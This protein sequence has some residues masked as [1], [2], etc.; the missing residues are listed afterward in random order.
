MP[1]KTNRLI[2]VKI[3]CFVL[4][5]SL[6]LII[7]NDVFMYKSGTDKYKDFYTEKQQ[8]DAL[9]FGSSR[10]LEA[11]QPMELWKEYGIRSYNM[12]QHGEGLGRDYWQLRCALEKKVP[13]VVVMDV[14]AFYGLYGID[15][16]DESHVGALHKQI[17]H[18]PLSITKLK[19]IWEL[20][21][22]GSR[23]EFVFPFIQYH[24]RWNDISTYDFNYRKY[25]NSRKG[26]DVNYAVQEQTRPLWDDS[27]MEE[28]FPFENTKI[29]EIVALCEE[30][31]TSVLFINVP[32][33]F[34][35]E[36]MPMISYISDYFEKNNIPYINFQRD[37]DFLD[38][39]ID[40]GDGF[41]LNI[42]GSHKLTRAFGQYFTENYGITE[43]EP[44]VKEEWDE[45][46]ADYMESKDRYIVDA[47]GYLELLMMVYEDD[48][49]EVKIF[50]SP[51]R[52]VNTG[53]NL[54]F[55]GLEGIEGYEGYRIEVYHAGETEP[56]K[57]WECE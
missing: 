42:G 28:D 44:E 48:D 11:I 1:K 27:V 47:E 5:M 38:Y 12:A 25:R 49:Y 15:P 16:S 20:C 23:A 43:T 34:G 22:K 50:S 37:E 31:G 41:H 24:S 33:A 17:D 54:F 3:I 45:V 35:E 53:T 21:P 14:S 57:I 32:Y 30:Y 6:L 56:I 4:I 13:R 26:A 55:E 7:S 19:M 36:I 51:E 9:F 18:I 2:F 46:F 52:I 40:F 10:V 29:E 8:F 39:S